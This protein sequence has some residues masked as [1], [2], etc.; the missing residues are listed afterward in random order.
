MRRSLTGA[1][2]GVLPENED[3][4]MTRIVIELKVDRL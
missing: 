4:L 3:D 2:I 1:S